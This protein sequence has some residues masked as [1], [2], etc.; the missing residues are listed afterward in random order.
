MFTKV[1]PRPLPLGLL[2]FGYKR[3]QVLMVW[4]DI[5]RR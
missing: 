4:C 2:G 5:Y 3:S 1:I